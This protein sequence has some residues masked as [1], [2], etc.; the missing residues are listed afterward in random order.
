MSSISSS[1]SLARLLVVLGFLGQVALGAINDVFNVQPGTTEG[2]CDD[3]KDSLD[4]WFADSQTLINAAAVGVA[5]TDADSLSYLN[6]FFSI[7]P[8][9][10]KKEVTRRVTRVQ[11]VLDN[12]KAP[13]GG[14]PWLF[15]DSDWVIEQAWDAVALDVATGK[16][17]PAN[18]KIEDIYGP[19]DKQKRELSPFWNAKIGYVF[20]PPGDY[21][22]NPDNMGATQDG[23]KPSTVTLCIKNFKASQGVT[24][25]DI[26]AVTAAGT[27]IHDLQTHSLTLFHE[28]FHLALGLAT[29]P[30]HSYKLSDILKFGIRDGTQNPESFAM[31]ALAYHLGQT[32]TGFTFADGSSVSK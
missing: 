24:L 17:F 10:S 2:G 26:P 7:K 9:G 27:S 8:A 4:K 22:S 20:S 30:D 12:T 25:A 14:K 13:P 28:M 6:G 23:T 31:Y 19:T 5:A 16:P 32:Y 1:L 3:H 15:C 29:T 18:D 21:C 11:E